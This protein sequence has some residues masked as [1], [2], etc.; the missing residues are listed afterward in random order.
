MV[1][2]LLTNASILP[3][4]FRVCCAV[5]LQAS[6]S[7]TSADNASASAFNASHFFTIESASSIEL[8][9]VTVTFHPFEARSFAV[10]APTPLLPPV[11][12]ATGLSLIFIF[13]STFFNAK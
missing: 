11:T 13:L 9:H 7:E 12:I 2:A 10:A 4:F 8:V 1:P 6:S 5:F 3:H